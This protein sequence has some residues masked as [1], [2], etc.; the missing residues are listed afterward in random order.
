ML[1]DRVYTFHHFSL[2]DVLYIMI[3]L[4]VKFGIIVT[5]FACMAHKFASLNVCTL[6]CSAASCISS[7]AVVFCFVFFEI[8]Y[9]SWYC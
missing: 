3:K 1:R 6:N 9:P 2:S 4:I 7:I 5:R 8:T